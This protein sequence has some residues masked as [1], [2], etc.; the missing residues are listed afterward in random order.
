M[1]ARLIQGPRDALVLKGTYGESVQETGL[2][3]G[4]FLQPKSENV[5]KLHSACL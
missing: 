3:T 2:E 1:Y 5:G 4:P